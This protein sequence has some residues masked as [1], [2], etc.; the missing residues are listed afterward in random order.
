MDYAPTYGELNK[1]ATTKEVTDGTYTPAT[2]LQ[3]HT[4]TGD[5]RTIARE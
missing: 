5:S 1:F 3:I 4:E 2:P